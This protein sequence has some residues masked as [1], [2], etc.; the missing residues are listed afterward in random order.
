[1]K[2]QLLLALLAFWASVGMV[3]GNTVTITPTIST[4]TFEIT[5]TGGKPTLPQGTSYRESG[6]TYTITSDGT[7][8]IE[9]KGNI[10]EKTTGYTIEGKVEKIEVDV[11]NY[12]TTLELTGT[13]ET[14]VITKA[15]GI[16]ALDL[17]NLM[18]LKS[19]EIISASSLA[20]L[21]LTGNNDL[22]SIKVPSALKPQWS[23]EGISD[24]SA[25]GINLTSDV[26]TTGP[27]KYLNGVTGEWTFAAWKKLD[28]SNQTYVVTS[29]ARENPNE[30]G[31][32]AFY[33]DERNYTDGTYSC[34]VSRGDFSILL[35]DIR[36]YPA[37]VV[38]TIPTSDPNGWGNEITGG[39]KP[40]GVTI[41]TCTDYSVDHDV[42][43]VKG[44]YLQSYTCHQGDKVTIKA[45]PQSD[46]YEFLKFESNEGLVNERQSETPSTFTVKA[47][48]ESGSNPAEQEEVM[49]KAV[50]KGKDCKISY[51]E[52]A[53]NGKLTIRDA[54]NKNKLIA[55][56]ETVEYGHKLQIETIP[57]DMSK[58]FSEYKVSDQEPDAVNSH[59]TKNADFRTLNVADVFVDQDLSITVSFLPSSYQ[60]YLQPPSDIVT[61]SDTYFADIF[62]EITIGGE[63]VELTG[64][65]NEPVSFNSG[66]I[67]KGEISITVV[68]NKGYVVKS[69][70]MGTQALELTN[71]GNNKFTTS[72]TASEDMNTS[73]TI[74]VVK[75]AEVKAYI[76]GIELGTEL[77]KPQKYSYDKQKHGLKYIT[78]PSGL[79]LDVLYKLSTTLLNNDYTTDVPVAAGKYEVK[80]SRK[81]DAYE[82]IRETAVTV[83][84]GGSPL[85]ID[86]AAIMITTPPTV[87]AQRDPNTDEYTFVLAGGIASSLGENVT[88]K[89]AFEVLAEPDPD[90]SIDIT[91]PAA[92]KAA[93]PYVN[94]LVPSSFTNSYQN[95]AVRFMIKGEDE[96]NYYPAA[97]RVRVL[98]G[99]ATD[100]KYKLVVNS[101]I[102]T[103]ENEPSAINTVQA[104]IYNGA[105][106]V[107][108][109]KNT[110]TETTLGKGM[111]VYLRAIVDGYSTVGFVNMDPSAPSP[112]IATRLV[113]GTTN[114]FET[115][116]PVKLDK[117]YAF[118][119][120]LSGKLNQI[121]E[122]KSS[123]TKTTTYNGE[124]QA[125]D[126]QSLEIKKKDGATVDLTT[127]LQTCPIY[128]K[129]KTGIIAGAPVEVGEYD[130]CIDIPASVDSPEPHAAQ[131]LIASKVWQIRP[132]EPTVQW[133][134]GVS[135]IGAGLPLSAA[136]FFTDGTADVDGTFAWE[137][138]TIVPK[139][140]NFYAIKFIPVDTKNYTATTFSVEDQEKDKNYENLAIRISSKLVVAIETSVPHGRFIVKRGNAEYYSGDEVEDGTT[141]TITP[142]ADA[143]F[144]CK[145]L[146][147]DEAGTKHTLS[148][149]TT[150]TINGKSIY[151]TGE[152]GEP[153]P[154]VPDP[155]PEPETPEPETPGSE[156]QYTITLP[157]AGAVK[158]VIVDK[159]GVNT[160]A[161]GDSFSFTL[162]TLAE[163]AQNVVVKVDGRE[164]KPLYGTYNVYIGQCRRK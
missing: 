93:N 149:E 70:L 129:D 47:K 69:I 119:I 161:E 29:E 17:S 95:V 110:K 135:R 124:P 9:I 97:T 78:D 31:A 72:F 90:V 54:S 126:P 163:D 159:T 141:L 64:K 143:G 5:W 105:T 115:V 106:R 66:N 133:P 28:E 63:S 30:V 111:Q 38:I 101:N 154:I 91:D 45:T 60:I 43:D 117:D 94:N 112:R 76:D 84:N 77:S 33:D 142:V 19:L 80:V 125:Y 88:S 11:E 34:E 134:T 103:V 109:G 16:G 44:D 6:N 108:Y 146:V 56:G 59:N 24:L 48:C 35:T 131:T 32:F 55:S 116:T 155:T 140:G 157:E 3:K 51:N 40:D 153:S 100:S 136:Q 4:G 158:G 118:S 50:F 144:V 104:E 98:V 1:M 96:K 65:A 89:G 113:A 27:L 123:V 130:V 121:Y 138:G 120:D 61:P 87:T 147:I 22:A 68:D 67:K 132:K 46:N 85:V 164:L 139:D 42:T 156:T 127:L 82:K 41:V 81:A 13:V 37:K 57:A 152:F 107:A 160:V 2:Q 7:K 83:E 25:K 12:V 145:R 102:V 53:M 26:F 21:T 23:A 73:F 150:F 114:T 75:Q 14:L 128:Y 151:I 71:E 137:D 62:Q 58:Y 39:V 36:I 52:R 162:E 8:S 92:L 18:G 79:T 148:G 10:N 49:V 15:N 20:S 74:V 86:P 99:K 122:L